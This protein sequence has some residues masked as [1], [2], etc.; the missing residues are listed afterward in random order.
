MQQ[1][2]ASRVPDVAETALR[3]VEVVKADSSKLWAAVAVAQELVKRFVPRIH[4]ASA[5]LKGPVGQVHPV[6]PRLIL[7]KRPGP[8]IH[9]LQVPQTANGKGRIAG[10]VEALQAE[11]NPPVGRRMQ[12]GNEVGS[13][14]GVED[15][16][17]AR[18]RE[19]LLAPRRFHVVAI[20]L[21]HAALQLDQLARPEEAADEPV[22]DEW[23]VQEQ[24]G[25][26]RPPHC[27]A[28]AGQK[29]LHRFNPGLVGGL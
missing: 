10:Q 7:F 12:L 23:D 14:D 27:P 20:V 9:G 19:S 25:K 2:G 11:L 3:A 22:E 8:P 28:D 24:Q 6:L 26:K 16:R 18:N 29:R 21:H 13:D 4:Q 17:S 15:A 1:P 5:Q